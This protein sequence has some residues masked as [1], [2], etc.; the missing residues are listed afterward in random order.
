MWKAKVGFRTFLVTSL[1]SD[2]KMWLHASLNSIT[3]YTHRY[4]YFIGSKV[5]GGE[6]KNTVVKL[7]KNVNSM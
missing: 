5:Y 1:T 3:Y 4:T 7:F 6:Y 2:R